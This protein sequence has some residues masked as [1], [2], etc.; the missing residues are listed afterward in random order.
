MGKPNTPN[1]GETQREFE[2]LPEITDENI[3]DVK[4]CEPL[5]D[6]EELAAAA[7][8]KFNTSPEAV[9]TALKMANKSKATLTEAKN[10][11]SA[12]LK[13]EVQ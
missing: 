3:N 5:Y 8:E 11:V 12:F 10:T 13:K 4:T 1:V 9:R 2:P 6:S 7:R